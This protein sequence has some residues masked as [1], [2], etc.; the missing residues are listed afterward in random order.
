MSKLMHYA[1]NVTGANAYWNKARDNLKS[2]HSAEE[3]TNN[4]LD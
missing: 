4:I 2:N 3:S 1:E